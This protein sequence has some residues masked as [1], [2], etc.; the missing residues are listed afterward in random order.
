MVA[1]WGGVELRWHAA[2]LRGDRS[3][4]QA[5]RELGVNRDELSRIERGET[6]QIRFET[7]AKLVSG[8]HCTLADLLEV[9][10][11]GDPDAAPWSGPLAAIREGRVP[12]GLP[13]RPDPE[14]LGDVD[15][16]TVPASTRGGDV[17]AVL[18]DEG[19]DDRVRRG[20]FRP[21][22]R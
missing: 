10:S 12:A 19:L 2:E 5:A 1:S 8:Y 20:A 14:T 6:V 4:A 3:L 9:A 15:E 13:R 16:V 22:A 21:T 18:G 17:A 11:P 7:L